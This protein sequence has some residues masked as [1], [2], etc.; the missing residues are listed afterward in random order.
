MNKQKIILDGSKVLWHQDRLEQWNFGNGRI[1]PVTI[2]CAITNKCNYKCMY[3]Y[4]K[5][6]CKEQ[7]ELD[8]DTIMNFLEDAAEIGVKGVTF[9]GDGENT[10]NKNLTKA[11]IHGNE[12]GMSMALG[13]NGYLLTE[14]ILGQI[15]PRLTYLRIN[16]SAG[17][18]HRYAK[19]HGVSENAFYKV[20]DNIMKAVEL[21]RLY[22]LGV[23]I[24]LQMVLM[25][26]FSDQI[27]P[28]TKLGE[29]MG[30]DY[31]VIKHCSDDEMG[32]LGIDYDKYHD[33]VE[34]L[35]EAEAYSNEKYQVT[36]KWSKLM[37]GGQ[38]KYCKCFGA[39][40]L[41]QISGTG[42][43][44]PCGMFFNQKYEKYHIGNLKEKRFKDIWKSDRYWE[45][46]DMIKS[47]N[48]NPN[49]DCGTL[50]MQHNTNNVLWDMYNKKEIFKP[51][52]DMPDHINF[53]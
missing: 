32:T 34:I 9:I 51:E 14:D 52:G 18:A 37:S 44:A 19:I 22:N 7:D 39:P 50:C 8:Y 15:L 36:V 12:L 29:E 48:F 6:Q 4:G 30:V 47:D 53:I 11:I 46:M 43:V 2:E 49:R 28:L 23:T 13:T 25:P 45:V 35:K 42:L 27:I 10:C 40:F 20:K 3:C 16:I 38:K 33:M 5:M 24:G 41:L 17:E 1:A 21:K 31:L 26:E